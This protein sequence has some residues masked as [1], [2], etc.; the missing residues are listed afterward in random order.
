MDIKETIKRYDPKGK[1]DGMKRS[2]EEALELSYTCGYDDGHADGY[3]EGCA[4]TKE[5]DNNRRQAFENGRKQGQAEAWEVARRIFV[6]PESGGGFLLEELM[7]IFQTIS[8]N[9][10]FNNNTFEQAAE[11]IRK[12][13]EKEKVREED[14]KIGDEVTINIKWDTF[15]W[16]NIIVTSNEGSILGFDS[17]GHLHRRMKNEVKKT[18]RHFDIQGILDQMGK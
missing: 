4:D 12:Y 14:I 13:E 8:L 7:E 18:G 9:S 3:E 6:D 16:K 5:T 11:K 1:T 15:Y 2:N 10:I 17:N